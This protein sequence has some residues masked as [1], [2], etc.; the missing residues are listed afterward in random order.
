MSGFDDNTK[1]LFA[2][3]ESQKDYG[4]TYDSSTLNPYVNFS[5]HSNSQT[6]HDVLVAEAIQMRGVEAVYI[7]REMENIDL[8]FGEDPTSKFRKTFRIAIYVENFE[9]WDGDQDWM[10]KFGFMVNDEMNFTINPNLFKLQAD[11]QEPREGDLV[12]FPMAN[13]LFELNWVERE[14]PWYQLGT[15]PMRKIRA[16]K[17]IYSGE[18]IN[19]DDNYVDNVDGIFSVDEI[20]MSPVADLDGRFDTNIEQGDE[21]EQV[22]SEVGV[23]K[24]SESKYPPR[25]PSTRVEMTLNLDN[26]FDE[27]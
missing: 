22:E 25:A 10:S 7:R 20:D 15:L 1:S 16:Q 13:S 19:L 4:A 27:F 3:L 11:G 12:Y 6:L 21:V 5:K 2:R 23:F 18:E 26:P 14:Q 9:G 24:E 17:F 8:V